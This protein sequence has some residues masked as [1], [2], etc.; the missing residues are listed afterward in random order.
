MGSKDINLIMVQAG[1][2][3]HYKRYSHE[4]PRNQAANYAEA[5]LVARTE[6][7]GLWQH[8]N[9]VPPWLWR[10]SRTSSDMTDRNP[11][12]ISISLRD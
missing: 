4:Q 12:W 6:S 7:R 9:P 5:E 11:S 1:L 3:W 8:D 2:A 10:K